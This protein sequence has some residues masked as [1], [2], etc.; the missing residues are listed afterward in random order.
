MQETDSD[1]ND[2]IFETVEKRRLRIRKSD[3]KAT[4]SNKTGCSK[5]KKGSK[6]K[7]KDN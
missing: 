1:G 2:P 3:S 7:K 6:K 4:E 5:T